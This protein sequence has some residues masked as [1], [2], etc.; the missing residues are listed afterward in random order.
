[1]QLSAQILQAGWRDLLGWASIVAG[2]AV[3]V[4]TLAGA[5]RP[6]P[7]IARILRAYRPAEWSARLSAHERVRPMDPADQ[8]QRLTAIAEKA[9][10]QVEAAAD[11]HARAAQELEAVDDALV[12]LLADHAAGAMVPARQR[13]VA[14]APAPIAEPLAA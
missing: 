1:M 4:Q 8:L 2:L 11:L 13:E 6:R 9:F 12:R 5:R 14:P 7:G 10:T 3:A